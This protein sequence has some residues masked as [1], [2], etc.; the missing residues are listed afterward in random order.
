MFT[1]KI[2]GLTNLDDARW[3]LEQGADYLGFV[4]YPKSPRHVAVEAL[5]KIVARLPEHARTV[6]VFVNMEPDLVKQ[7]ASDC[8]LSAVQLNGDEAPADFSDFSVPVWR[9]VRLEAGR[10]NPVPEQWRAERFVLDAASP[11]YGGS[12]LKIDWAV[13][14]DFASRHP[15]MLAGGL[16]PDSVAEAIRQVRPMGVDVSSG[17]ECSPGKKDFRKVAAFIANARAVA[18]VIE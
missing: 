9:A 8:R 18:G 5:A 13:G 1:V 10:W 3:A 7:I 4:L 12:G 16:E 17:V 15:A 11:A 14:R 2:C 6:G